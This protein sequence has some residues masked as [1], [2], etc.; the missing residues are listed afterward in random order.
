MMGLR[1]T[2]REI[3]NA[4]Y[5]VWRI[6]FGDIRDLWKYIRE[7]RVRRAGRESICPHQE[8]SRMRAGERRRMAK[9]PKR[10]DLFGLLF[11]LEASSPVRS[12]LRVIKEDKV[13]NIHARR[14]SS[15]TEK[16]SLNSKGNPYVFTEH[17]ILML[18]SVLRS[19]RAIQINIQ[20]MRTFNRLRE[21]LSTHEE[22]KRK[23]S[24]HDHMINYLV[25]SVNE[26]LEPY[27]EESKRRIYGKRD[28]IF[29]VYDY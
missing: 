27:F 28:R 12:D 22:I 4:E 6:A 17:G 13:R 7:I 10:S 25:E 23:L 18:S 5:S 16:V 3:N 24:E 15:R 1:L 21:F 2:A 29:L 19:E 14:P 20:I 26:L 11:G 9:K 8:V